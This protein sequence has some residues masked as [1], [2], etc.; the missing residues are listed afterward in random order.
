MKHEC[1]E[2]KCVKK[3]VL[4]CLNKAMKNC[5]TYRN[6]NIPIEPTLFGLNVPYANSVTV[7]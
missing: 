1:R 6:F 4:L 2:K 7:R 3:I 5:C